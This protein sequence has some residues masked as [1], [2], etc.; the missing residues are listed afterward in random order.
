MQYVICENPG[1]VT[2]R[3]KAPPE[4]GAGEVLLKV[5]NIGICG[6]DIH[7]FGG[8]QAFFTY[9]RILGHELS[10][11]VIQTG[12]EHSALSTGDRVVVMPYFYCGKCKACEVGKT[13]CC[14]Q[15]KVFGVHIDGGMQEMISV[16][17]KFL[18]K[19]NQL[20]DASAA[21]IEPLSIGAHALR[22]AQPEKEG[23]VLV[24][25]CGPIGL[26]I[27]KQANIMGLRTI[28]LDI[29]EHRLKTAKLF[30]GADE[31][32]HISHN[33]TTEVESLTQGN[34][35]DVVIDATGNKNALENGIKYMRHGGKYVLVGLYKGDLTFHHPEIHAKETSLLCSRNATKEDFIQVID[36]LEKQLFPVDQYITLKRPFQQIETQFKKWISL[37]EQIKIIIEL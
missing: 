33:T 19:V 1:V 14:Q 30:F 23:T 3:E 8:N 34:L 37:P 6:T 21:I 25:G 29:D 24:M 2:S 11:E 31:A 13:N 12:S 22:R 7:A 4:P 26:G 32:V 15:L 5:R 28:A 36:L 16:S 9:P 18:I 20:T 35:A 10:A 27:I 17:E